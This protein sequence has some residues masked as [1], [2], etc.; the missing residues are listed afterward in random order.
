MRTRTALLRDLFDRFQAGDIFL[1]DCYF[2]SYFLLARFLAP[3]G[4]VALPPVSALQ[5]E[6]G[7]CDR[8]PPAALTRLS[9]GALALGY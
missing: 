9:P 3:Q 7:N 4:L 2:C 5:V 6:G 1:G 8:D